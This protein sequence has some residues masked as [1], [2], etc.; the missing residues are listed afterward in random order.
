MIEI[1]TNSLARADRES[2]RGGATIRRSRAYQ[3][4]SSSQTAISGKESMAPQGLEDYF[5]FYNGLRPHQALG[6]RTP[7]EVF[8]GESRERRCSPEK[9]T[10]SLAGGSEFSLNSALTLSK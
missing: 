3:S 2:H 9:G 4:S 7:A 8:H 6:Y 1:T 10:E 5:R